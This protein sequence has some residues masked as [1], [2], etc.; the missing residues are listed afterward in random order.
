MIVVVHIVTL[1]LHLLSLMWPRPFAR[2]L[3]GGVKGEGGRR[4]CWLWMG[5]LLALPLCWQSQSDCGM[6]FVTWFPCW[7]C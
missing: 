4:V 6:K 2:W 7:V 3:V 1:A 5:C